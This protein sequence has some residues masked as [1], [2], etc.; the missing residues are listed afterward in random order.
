[1]TKYDFVLYA[2]QCEDF[3]EQLRGLGLVDITTTGWE[4]S[5][6]D[7]QLLLD[8]EGHTK[9]FNFLYEL[10]HD[11]ERFN[12]DAKPFTTGAEAYEHFA[13]AH[14][15]AIALHAEIARLEKTADELRPWGE[16]SIDRTRALA[17]KGIVLRYFFTPKNNYDK[18]AGT[19]AEQFTL[20]PVNRTESTV[21]F[22]VVTAPGEEIA[23]DAQEMKTPT[24]DIREAEHQITVARKELHKLDAEFSRVEVSR[25]LLSEHAA[26]LKERLED[27]RVKAT[28][29][30]AA[31]DTLMIME[32]WVET[33]T[34]EK[35]D[36]LL[37]EY[38]NIVYLKSDPTPEDETPVKLKNRWFP[39][40]FELVGDMYA[41]PKYGTMDLTPFFA[42]FYMLFFGICLNDAG[43]GAIL[44]GLGLWMLAKNKQP[45]MM[46]KAA[47]FA[48][49]CGF[50]TIVVGL[51]CGSFFGLSLGEYFPSIPFYDFQGQFFPIALSIGMVQILFGMLLKI[52]MLS[53]TVGFRYSLGSLGWFLILLGVCIA[54][55]LPLLNEN[56]VI[57]F[58]TTSSPAFYATMGLGVILMLFFNSPGKNPFMNFGL[59]LWD[60]YN[61]ITGILSD[62]L[63]YIRLFAIGLS[64]G[65][66]ATVFNAL[67]TGFVPDDAN[68]LVRI[69]IMLPILLVGHGIN[70]FMSTIS[71]FVHPMRLTFVEFYKNAG[72]EMS[73]RSF[74]PLQKTD[75]SE[76]K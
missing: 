14:Q 21:Y 70:L 6:E 56:W 58:Y 10:R 9:A 7:R 37:E 48:T 39:R 41:R 32:G 67:A 42:P 40:I 27:A 11:E 57:P 33:E 54:G 25:Q 18:F 73:M 50:T 15:K 1:M 65:I 76:N 55:G 19:W 5:E 47:W 24:M 29:Q 64:G 52:A 4:P 16:F 12:A 51:I 35:V 72:F 31:D 53:M 62:V 28:S 2:A 8:I 23:L 43:Y 38:P 3:I 36:A 75:N 49:L 22:V 45:G 60:T 30:Q 17:E 61:N 59:G 63:S 44:T 74:E 34:A 20:S 26:H 13:V 69:L 71:S 68:I 46:R 66:L